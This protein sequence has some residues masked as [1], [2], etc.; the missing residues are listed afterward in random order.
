M[1]A[2]HIFMLPGGYALMLIFQIL[3]LS[4]HM[5][6]PLM[7]RIAAALLSWMFWTGALRVLWTVTCAIFGLNGPRRMQ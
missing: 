7:L 4:P 1:N 6:D 2:A 5:I 3:Q